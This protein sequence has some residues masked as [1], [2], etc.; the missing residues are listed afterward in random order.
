MAEII[1]KQAE[2][3]ENI[4]KQQPLMS[5]DDSLK[6]NYDLGVIFGMRLFL[7]LPATL[8]EIAKE[9]FDSQLEEERKNVN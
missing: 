1:T 5:T 7:K 3:R 4:I 6:R 9:D 8:Q 2:A